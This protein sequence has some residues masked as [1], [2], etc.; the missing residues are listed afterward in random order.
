MEHLKRYLTFFS[1]SQLKNVFFEDLCHDPQVLMKT[2]WEFIGVDPNFT[3]NNAIPRNAAFGSRNL[4]RFVNIIKKTYV[5]KI[6][7]QKIRVQIREGLSKIGKRPK[8]EPEI[9]AWLIDYYYK[10]NR[11]LEELTGRDLSGWDK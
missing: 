3:L 7:P 10:Y 6:L 8:M 11:E 4:I 1:E 9:R 5:Q 2:I